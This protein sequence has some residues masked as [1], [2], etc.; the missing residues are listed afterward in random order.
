MS[1]LRTPPPPRRVIG[2]HAALPHATKGIGAA[3]A[4][5]HAMW[6]TMISQKDAQFA[7]KDAHIMAL[8]GQNLCPLVRLRVARGKEREARVEPSWVRL[9]RRPPRVRRGLRGERR[10]DAQL[11]AGVPAPQRSAERRDR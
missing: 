5:S 2:V 7:Q 10:N 8:F 3:P 1:R 6:R 11:S 4:M 9:V